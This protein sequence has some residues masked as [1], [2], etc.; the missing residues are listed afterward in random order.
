MKKLSF[1]IKI[2]LVFILSISGLKINAQDNPASGTQD[3]IASTPKDSIRDRINKNALQLPDPPSIQSL[4]TYDPETNLFYFNQKVGDFNISYP[5]V[6]TPEEYYKRVLQ[7]G[8]NKNFKDRNKAISGKD[9]EAKKLQKNLLPIYYVNSKFFESVFGGNVIDIQPKGS[10]SVDLGVRYT[11]RDNPA[12]PINNRSRPPTLDFNEK[13]SVGLK[14]K[15][16]T[17]LDLDLNYDTHSTFNFNNQVKLDFSPNEDDII[18]NVELGNVSMTSHNALIQGVQSLL[19]LKTELRF[20]NTYI[21]TVV[22][23]QRSG[24]R[25]IQAQGDKVVEKFEQ[26]IL[27]Y[28]ENKHFFLA[29]YF[30]EHYDDALKNYPFINSTVMITRIEVWKTNRSTQ[31]ENIRNIVALQDLGENQIIGLDTPP[32]GFIIDPNSP[33]DNSVNKFDPELIGAGGALNPNIREIFSVSQGFTGVNPVN[34]TDYVSMENTVKLDSTQYVLHP[35]LGYI[36]LKQKL[37]PDE[38]LAVAFEYTINGQIYRVGEFSDN[39][40]VYP[41]TLIVKLLKSNMVSTEEPTWNLMMKNIY[42]LNAYDIDPNDFRLNILYVN[43]TPFNYIKPINGVSLPPDVNERILLNVFNMDRLTAQGDPQPKGDGFFD[44]IPGITIDAREGRVIFTST[45]PFGKYLFEKLRLSASENYDDIN[46]WN[47]NQKYYVYK[48]LYVLSKTQAE[49]HTEKNKFVLKGQYKTAGGDGIPIGGFNIP[50]GSVTVTAGG[51][52]LVEGIDYVV[53]YQL[54]RVNII[55]P[56]ISQANIPI[57]VSVEQNS[58]FQQTTKVFTGLEVEHRFSK[59]FT[60]GATYMSFKEKP[61][62]WK[63]NYGYEPLNNKLLGINGQFSTEVPF[64]TRWVNRLPNVESDAESNF[65]I[66]AEAAYLFP[67]LADVSDVNGRST[68]YIEDFESSQMFI[69]LRAQYAWH[70]ASVPARFPESQMLD[71]LESGKNRAKLSWYIIDNIFYNNSAP[72]DITKDDI[73]LEETRPI[74]LNEIFDQDVPAGY[75]AVNYPLNLTFYPKERGPYNFDTQLDP[76]TGELLFPEQRWGG[77]MRYLQTNDFEQANVEYLDIWIMDPYFNNPN[78][79]AGGKLYIDLGYMSEDILYDGR[80]QYENGL[81]GDGSDDYT[82]MTNLARVPTHQSI[83]YAFSNDADERPHQDVGLDGLPDSR[84]AV[85]FSNYL[86]SLPANLQNQFAN[87]PSADNYQNYMDVSGGIV[88][89]YKNFNGTEGN[90]PIDANNNYNTNTGTNTTNNNVTGNNTFPDVEDIDRDQSMNTIESYYEY[91]IDIKPNISINDPYVADIKESTVTLPNGNNQTSRWIQFKIPVHEYTGVVGNISDFRSIKFMRMYLNGFT[92]DRITLRFAALNL[93]RGD[94]KKYY[95]TLDPADPNPDD[96]GTFV[97]TSAISIQDNGTRQPIPYVLPPGIVREEIYQQ[98]SQVRQNEQALSL[99]VCDLEVKDGRGVYKYNSVDMRQ[100]KNLEMFIHAEAIDGQ[101]TLQDDDVEGFLRFGTDL[102]DNYY[103]IRIPLKVTPFGTSDPE[104]IWPLENR[105]DLKLE[106]LNKIK[107]EMI[108]THTIGTGTDAVFF[109]ESDLDPDAAGK[110]NQLKIGIKGNPNFGDV[111]VIMVG[112]RNITGHKVCG[113]YWFNELRMSEMKNKGGWA[114]NATIDA[115]LADFATL[116]FTGGISTEGFGGLEEGPLQRNLEDTKHYNFNSNVNLGRLLPKK[117]NVQIPVTYTISE[118]FITPKYDPIWRDI[119]V[120]DRVKIAETAQRDSIR[121]VAQAYTRHRGITLAGVKKGYSQASNKTTQTGNKKKNLKTTG[122]NTKQNKNKK[123]FYDIENFTFDFA[124]NEIFHS[125]YEIEGNKDETTRFGMNYSYN[126]KELSLEPFKKSKKLKSKKLRFIKDLNFNIMPS[127]LTVTSN[128]NRR[129]NNLNF[130]EIEDYGLSI[131]PLQNRDYTFD[132][133]YRINYNPTKSIQTSFGIT[134]NRAVK[135]YLLTDGST[136]YN[137]TIWTDYFNVGDPLTHSQDINVSY[138]LPLKKM[139][140][141]NFINAT[142]VYNG[143]FQWQ[144]RSEA[145]ADIDGFDLGNTIQNSNSHQLNV[146]LDMKKL[147]KELG[148]TDFQKRMLGKKGRKKKTK[149][150]KKKKKEN[151]KDT[152]KDKKKDKKKEPQLRGKK[153]QK[154]EIAHATTTTKIIGNIIGVLTGLQSFKINYRQNNGQMLPGY[155]ESVG[156]LGTTNPSIPFSL[157]WND[158]EIRYDAARRG[159]LTQ[160]PDFNQPYMETYSEE[161]SY[162]GTIKPLKVLS[163]T[164]KGQKS[165]MENLNE[166]F[167]AVGNQYNALVPTTM[168]NYSVSTILIN[169]A[170]EEVSLKN[171]PAFDRMLN[172]RLTIARRLAAERG[173]PVPVSGYPEGYGPLQSE[174]VYYAF[175]S[176]YADSDPQNISLTPFDKLPI[177]NWRIKLSGLT[178]IK[179]IKKAF[180]NLSIE[181]S[182]RSDYTVN[183]FTNNLQT[184]ENPNAKDASGNY[185]SPYVM[186]NITL[187]EAF[188]PLIKINMEMNNSLKMN[189]GLKKDRSISLNLNNFTLSEVSG[190][191]YTIGLGYRLK[192]I[193]LPLRIAGQR[194]EF[195]NDLILKLDASYRHN[196]TILRSLSDNNNQVTAGQS[197]Y[198]LK[199]SADYALTK[200]LT[201]IIFYNHSYSEYEISTSYPFTN[202]RGGFTIKYTFG[203]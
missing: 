106:L 3:S 99:K 141:L 15:V 61:I 8:I 68:T 17:R 114:S 151:E 122:K 132:W 54:G 110:P 160:Y 92:D 144:K 29:Q 199:F 12:L 66:K 200:S 65:S 198:N 177:P 128:I 86:N 126:F 19:G 1:S 146:N 96:D 173:V 37:N 193:T 45:E 95:L 163:I 166:Q 34:G 32:P 194:M 2:L 70:L 123:H 155:L 130:R 115:N 44:F 69:D 159:W 82:I 47:E 169:T 164:F 191:E 28:D 117:W 63:A 113:E 51:R 57:Q 76:N 52:T 196:I 21:T 189:V 31:T 7:E 107:L 182:Y 35:K 93:V 187:T 58:V 152:D 142:Y 165:Y 120:D 78:P 119:T 67:G 162:Q 5:W 88:E 36:T 26:P 91:A 203:N 39:G 30:A 170:F 135:N 158:D 6:L 102:S 129:F 156:F 13:I 62:S 188:N 33:P 94:W 90:T 105:I 10:F 171:S 183:Q 20:G 64:L 101:T 81:P 140:L 40:I 27:Q 49:Q 41:Q 71:N 121:S 168:G 125:D 16:G 179:W 23:E 133:G 108:R 176:G 153:K 197:M 73:S 147:Y 136:D 109:N 79:P 83:V 116:S 89:R 100:F 53:N 85:F 145:M 104:I 4:Y 24:M 175:L 112:V 9:E 134:H 202:I 77:I 161:V 143:T 50:R 56:S 178:K 111:K 75:S 103:E 192:D 48:E 139:P 22:A 195:T 131:P 97:E 38:V 150:K 80:K 157:G 59:D 25:S 201:A 184:F 43:P 72:S 14:G 60:L 42:A 186:D 84:E 172:N 11:K 74:N 118:E 174:V 149:K 87:D 190:N 138:N 185:Y 124:Y 154:T 167:N 55:N 127:N 181:H 18:Q 46:T 148:I 98:N 180:K 137:N